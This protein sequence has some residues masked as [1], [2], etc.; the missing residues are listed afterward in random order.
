MRHTRRVKSLEITVLF[1]LPLLHFFLSFSLLLM[2]CSLPQCSA[3]PRSRIKWDKR[4]WAQ[5]LGPWWKKDVFPLMC[6]FSPVM[7]AV[8]NW[9]IQYV[10]ETSVVQE[11]HFSVTLC[12]TEKHI[13]TSKYGIILMGTGVRIGG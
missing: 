10:L 13:G 8:R 4:S 6:C 1:S 5:P 11:S 7:L 12:C 2:T 9:L 3:S